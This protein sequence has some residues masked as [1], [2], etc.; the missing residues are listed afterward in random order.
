MQ[1]I[2]WES[3]YWVN[4]NNLTKTKFG[5]QDEYFAIAVED[6]KIPIVRNYIAKQEEHHSKVS[7]K[8]EYD[9][10]IRRYGFKIIKK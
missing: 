7:Y 9:I 6:E 8:Q 4:K 2:K 10:F 3:A 5:W 1:L